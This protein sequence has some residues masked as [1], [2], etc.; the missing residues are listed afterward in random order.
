MSA[1]IS[2][3]HGGWRQETKYRYETETVG[4]NNL[5][6]VDSSLDNIGSKAPRHYYGADAQLVL[7][8]EWGKTEWRGEYWRGTQPGT[9]TTTVNP[10][11]LPMVPTYIRKFDGA[12]FYFLQNIINEKWELVVKYDWYDPNT[13]VAAT[14]VGKA[15]TNFTV[16]D[17]K[18]STLGAG[19]TR[20]FSGNLKLLAYYSLV[21]NETTAL[22]GYTDD[23]ADDV[24]TFRMQL[25]F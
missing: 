23:L 17:I 20:Y 14:E 16:A 22:N 10:G 1:G 25:R 12:F 5:F 9:A 4:A 2:L 3:L 15:G 7:K 8:H 21:R 13:K 24:F 19:L 6:V 18:F 11:T